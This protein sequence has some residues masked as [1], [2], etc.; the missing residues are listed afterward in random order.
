MPSGDCRTD[1]NAGDVRIAVTGL[2]FYRSGVF[3]FLFAY[4]VRY[5]G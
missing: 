2:K 1:S 4:I 3:F 5:L